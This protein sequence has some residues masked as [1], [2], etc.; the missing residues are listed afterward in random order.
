M[1]DQQDIACGVYIFIR[2]PS[3]RNSLQ[4]PS[5]PSTSTPP[6]PP[7]LGQPHALLLYS[8]QSDP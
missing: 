7:G 6:R 8:G 4:T 3:I 5:F 1:C 2:L